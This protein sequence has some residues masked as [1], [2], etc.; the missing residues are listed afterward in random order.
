MQL[1]PA[2]RR[3]GL[4]RGPARTRSHLGKRNQAEEIMVLESS[5][6]AHALK[7]FSVNGVREVMVRLGEAFHAETGDEVHF[8][9][10]TIGVLQNR[11]S[12]GDLP[13]VLVA[14]AAVMSRAEEQGLIDKNASVEVG[15]TGLGLAVKEGAAP[16]PDVS[17]SSGLR[18]TLLKARSL[19]YTDPRTGAA[20]GVAFAEMLADM[21][22]ADA[23]KDKAVLVSGGP[24][25]EVVAQGRAELGVQQ[26]TELLPIKGIALLGSL[27][28][29][30][31]RVT[32]YQ[33]AVVLRCT[34][35]KL[36]AAFLKYVTSC[37]VKPAFT[38]AGFGRY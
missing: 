24:V 21:G 19:A 16:L 34:K 4:A 36:A 29:E 23:V 13:D 33:A 22:I 11:M 37:K 2:Q 30:Q 25:G 15:R 32:V 18:D 10:G 26:V 5:A 27:P 35:P 3:A 14:M 31:Q 6:A 1:M 9:F 38:D 8:T 17:T 28:P 12:A 7:V 20:S